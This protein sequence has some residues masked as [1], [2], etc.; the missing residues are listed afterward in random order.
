MGLDFTNAKIT[1]PWN[2]IYREALDRYGERA[3]TDMMIEEMSELTKAL[4]KY[5][6]AVAADQLTRQHLL[7]VQEEMAD[8]TIML[9][10]MAL[11]YGDCTQQEIAKMERLAERLG[12]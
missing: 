10:Q 1:L 9:R 7:D 12:L 11:I 5:R 3:Q 8:V 6:R 4:L 2:D